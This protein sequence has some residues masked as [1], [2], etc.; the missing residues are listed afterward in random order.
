M[1]TAA[2]L[3]I[4]RTLV[5]HRNDQDSRLGAPGRG[6]HRRQRR[7]RLSCEAFAVTAL[8][9]GDDDEY[10]GPAHHLD[11]PEVPGLAVATEVRLGREIVVVHQQPDAAAFG[12]GVAERDSAWCRVD[13]GDLHQHQDPERLCTW[14]VLRL[15]FRRP[16]RV[17]PEAQPAEADSASIPAPYLPVR[18][19]PA[20]K[21]YASAA[22][23]WR[24]SGDSIAV[25]CIPVQ[26]ECGAA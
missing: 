10:A 9:G 24:H 5:C 15:L 7:L 25:V 22:T 20:E 23:A 14:S 17:S 16:V 11:R 19:R 1:S 21:E 6:P 2:P 18:S 26:H 8:V 13:A 4:H 3:G 12:E